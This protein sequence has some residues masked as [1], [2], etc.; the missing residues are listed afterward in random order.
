M[1]R[2]IFTFFITTITQIHFFL[3]THSVVFGTVYIAFYQSAFTIFELVY[4]V[5]ILNSMSSL[6]PFE[7]LLLSKQL[8]FQEPSSNGLSPLKGENHSQWATHLAYISSREPN[9]LLNHVRRIFIHLKLKQSDPLYGAMVDLFLVLGDKGERLRRSLLQ[10][11]RK[12][13]SQEQYDLFLTHLKHGLQPHYPLPASQHSVLGNFFGGEKRLV[14]AQ[15][16]KQQ[17]DT[18]ESDPLELAREELNYGDIAVAQRILEEA[19]LLSPKRLG[20]HYGLLEI[21]RHT[22]SLDDLINMQ[23]R[24]GDDIAHAQAAWNQTKKALLSKS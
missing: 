23:E 15:N 21:Y 14:S 3:V 18:R 11:S 24:L 1:L 2:H 12:L 13:L 17:S 20:L 16:D 9:N 6:Q 8:V 4:G 22:R 7:E 19:L 10:K 5:L